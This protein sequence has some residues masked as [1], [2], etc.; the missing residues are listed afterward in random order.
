MSVGGTLNSVASKTYRVELFANVSCDASGFGEGETFL[1]FVRRHD[2]N[3]WQWRVQLH[4][5]DTLTSG[6][7]ITATA[8]DPDG[9]TSEFSHCV[10]VAAYA[11]RIA[12]TPRTRHRGQRP[13]SS[14]RNG[15]LLGRVDRRS[16]VVGHLGLGEP[17]HRDDQRRRARPRASRAR[18]RSRRLSGRSAAT[19]C[20][21]SGR[22]H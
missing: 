16:D 1:G 9:N 7:F 15:Q 10:T 4:A 5:I 13:I 22:R 21:R 8:T 3:G 20:S 17:G 14:Y 11:D 2:R 19:R 12:V 18:A 6:D